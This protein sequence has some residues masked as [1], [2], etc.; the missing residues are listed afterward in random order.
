MNGKYLLDTNIVIALLQGN[1]VVAAFINGTDV[2][3]SAITVIELFSKEGIS[4][5][6]KKMINKLVGLA[7]ILEILNSKIRQLA[8]NCFTKKVIKKTPDAIIAS[9]AKFYNLTLVTQDRDFEKLL[10][11]EVILIQ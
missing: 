5:A 4:V 6:K 1:E 2:Y 11:V 7:T 3:L 8:A 10:D 9:T